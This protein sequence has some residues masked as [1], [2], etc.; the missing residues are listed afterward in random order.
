MRL[1]KHLFLFAFGLFSGIQTT[2]AQ[3]IIFSNAGTTYTNTDVVTSNTY[4]PVDISN[5]T[6]I[7][8]SVNYNFSLGFPGAGNM[9]SSDECP[10]NGG[11]AGD[12]NDPSGAGCDQCWD[13]F[14]AQFQIDGV[15]V[16]TQLV[17]V[18]GNLNQSGTLTFG[19]ICTQNGATA[20]LILQT[21]TWAA[22]ESVT[23]SN[24][25]ITCWDA[26]SANLMANPNPICFGQQFTLSATLTDPASVTS[27]QW[28][29][30]G[31]ITS[32][33]N[34]TTTVTGAPV[35]THTYTLTTTDDNACTET[36]T[37]DMTVNPG[38]TMDDPPNITICANDPVDVAFTGTGSPVYDW[39]NSNIGIGLGAS[40]SGDLSF[41]AANVGSATTGTVTVTPSEGGCIGPSQTFTI[42]VNPLPVVTQPNDVVVC[43]GAPVSVIFA[44]TAGATFNWTNDNTA[45]GLGASGAGNINFNSAS[46]ANQ[47]VGTVTVTP[48]RNGCPGLPITFTITVNPS[49]TVVDPPNQTVCS[50]QQVDINFTG[51]GNPDF[52]WTNSNTAIGLGANG[53]GDLSFTAS[54][55]V[56]NTTGTITVTPNANGCPGPN[57]TFTITV[58][59]LPSVNQPANVTVC[60]G[61][62]VAAIF[63][64]SA[65][66]LFSWSNDNTAIGLG[67][68]GIGNINFS[69]ANVSTQEVATITV[70]PITNNCPGNPVT[71]T[72]TINP[73]PTV[74]DPPNQT[75]CAGATVDLMFSGTVNPDFSWTN[76]NTAIGLGTSGTGDINF[77]AANVAIP[78]TGNL[79]VSPSENGCPG[80]PQNFTITVTPAPVMNQPSNVIACGGTNV[81]VFFIG[82]LG[83]TFNWTNSNPAIGLAAAGNGDLNF[84]ASGVTT[85]QVATITATPTVGSCAGLPV[86]FT[87]TINPAPTVVDP[88]NQ[89]VCSGTAVTVNFTG[90]NTPVFSWTN[91]NTNIGLGVSGTGN[92]SFTATNV[93]IGNVTVTPTAN[94][95]PGPSQTFEINVIGSPVVD[96]IVS[97]NACAGNPVMVAFTGTPG[98]AFS[99]TNSN[100]AIGLGASGTGDISFTAAGVT[101]V[102]TGTISVTPSLG[103]CTGTARNFDI[104]INPL[105]TLSISSVTC[106]ADLLTYSVVVSTNGTTVTAT[107]GTVSGSAGNFTISGIAAGTNVI[108]SSTNTA[109]GCQTTQT[110]NAPNCN[111]TPVAAPTTPNDPV[112]CEGAPIPALTVSVGAGIT[113]DWYS[114]ATGGTLLLMSNTSFTPTGPLAAGTYTFYAEA[115]EISS[116]CVSPVRTLVTLQINA[117]PTLTQP[118]D[119]T[120]CSGATVTADFVGT[121]GASFAWTNSNTNIGLGASG[122]GN[123][124][125]TA[126]NAGNTALT[127]NVVVT[128]SLNGCPGTP[129]NFNLTV[130][131]TP[132]VTAPANQTV[133]AGAMVGISLTGTVGATFDWTNSN[134]AIGLGASG[135]GDINFTASA[136]ASATI[137]NIS[138]TP[139]AGGCPGATQNFSITVNPAPSVTAPGNQS[140]C[141]G[142][143]VAVT[144][145]G[146]SGA[147]FNWTNS[148]T[149]IGLGASG[150]GNISFVGANTGST[151]LVANLV[152]TPNQNGCSG[153]AQNFTITINPLP[154][155]AVGNT[156]CA[157][158][159]LTYSVTVTSNATTLTSTAGTVTGNGSGFNIS[160]IPNGTNVILT[161]TNTSTN[162]STQVSV[163][164]PNCTC[165]TVMVPNGPN[166]PVICEGTAT[167]ALMVNVAPGFTVDWYAALTGGV[168]LLVGSTSFTPPG[169]FTP[170]TYIF[171]AES[172]DVAT[173]C[174]SST[175]TPVFLTVNA[176][177]TMTQPIDQAVC[178]GFVISVGFNGTSGANFNW[179]NSAPGIGL[180]ASGTGNIS[181]TSVNA[182]TTPIVATITVTPTLFG[183]FG[184]PKTFTITV[185]PSPTLTDPTDV[186]ACVGQSVAVNFSA[187]NNAT[188]TW[189]NT[190]T[191]IGLA[192]NGTGNIN[193]NA[194]TA[195]T[196][197][198]TVIPTAN[199]CSG[200]PQTFNIAVLNNPT[201]N[202]PG[203]VTACAGAAVTAG[204]TG[205]PGVNYSWT[206]SNPAIGLPA[207]GTGNISFNAANI[208]TVQSAQINVTPH[209]GACTGQ[210]KIF[211]ITINPLPVASITG[212]TTICNGD[213][214]A[215]TAAGGTSFSWSSGQT[216]ALINV[217]PMSTT[218]Y[219]AT[220]T[221]N[222][223]SATATATVKVNQ[224]T[225]ATVNALTC[226]PTQVGTTTNVITNVAG[227]DSTITTITTLDV[228]GCT[229]TAMLSNG[230]VSCFGNSN[231]VLSLSAA[232]GLGPYQYNWS[233][234]TQTG[235]GQITTAGTSVQLQNLPAGTYTVTVTGAN[236]LT[237]TVTAQVTSPA[238]LTAQATAVL[239]FGQYAISCVGATDATINATTTGG[240]GP[241]QF[242]W[243]EPGQQGAS[244]TGLGV[245]SYGVT[246]TDANLC[247]AT[248]SATVI[249]P[250]PLTF[251]LALAGVECGES[252]AIAS[253]TPSGGVN[254]FDVFV[255]GN[256]ATGGLSPGIPDGI[257]IVEIVDANGCA[258]DTTVEVVLPPVPDI[259]L[260]AELTVTLGETLVLEA[261]TNLTAW[262]SLVWTPQPDTSCIACL[263]QE[264][265]PSTS[266]VYEVDITDT[267]GCSASA[268]VRVIVRKQV[269]IYIPNVFSPNLD[270]INDFWTLDAGLS[271]VSLNSLQI[272]DRWGDMVYFW[273]APIPVDEW[274]GWDG[275]T[276]G[277]KVNPG[278]FVYYLEVTLANG[279]T[280]LKKGDLTVVR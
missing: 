58:V 198:V 38:P 30:P 279:E 49:P 220:V 172:R 244:I 137:A 263:R 227:C 85:Q 190:N 119:Q 2:G 277:E 229:P 265:I 139:T 24:I 221:S 255:D 142:G 230:A 177:P 82:T 146:S 208:L 29:G 102:T 241:F 262:Q 20:G 90:T 228:A 21:Q 107:A 15:N 103:G 224:A 148:N 35:G 204:F 122:N 165:P 161:A 245:G 235:T 72:I 97:V 134:T 187:T 170:G 3:T 57:Q 249:A 239:A 55:V 42:T 152:V 17:G 81:T 260:P 79:T 162:C 191:G 77:I 276:R 254:P 91:D 61:A 116:N 51:T 246:V 236:G 34:L 48:I 280:V 52:N 188:F 215:L 32:P 47:E 69:S 197:V 147:T 278:V 226:D 40:G 68:S 9:E 192:A 46:V 129:L 247:T 264:W 36:N 41:T 234:G 243:T 205:D 163:L 212:V 184:Q 259:V 60:S 211:T 216:T 156:T 96:T 43:A 180:P 213:G 125:F 109:T 203:N 126:T 169:V 44:G 225:T 271:V 217:T 132:S 1:S 22:N 140:A 219:T 112:I 207:S 10:F 18:P 159:L 64:G 266:Q 59:P 74:A 231:G 76:S 261:Q 252:V 71:F 62:P 238:L 105:P 272:F 95:C 181:F 117:V 66:A 5:C 104:T 53:M 167:P 121:I 186:S 182:G 19:P 150:A 33:N 157:P 144:F 253:I 25:T 14:Y 145:S 240:T 135:T 173:G 120:V 118:M 92:I 268:S 83:A 115:R 131:P 6:S 195:G 275:N 114:A 251:D 273:D 175:R 128:P 218:T 45:I 65:G 50:G 201:M 250:P 123:I 171:Y 189:T 214:T 258:A 26:S 8:F 183:C 185:N 101:G 100:T 194:N 158:D 174:V 11:C 7:S 113:V 133:C 78:I 222:G 143:T 110:V 94:G 270:G 84:I 200:T 223:C 63:S 237:Q 232:G 176:T 248:S 179:T 274:P 108:I 178:A 39:T 67:A 89:T 54:T 87:I 70:T 155:I 202:T 12:P 98:A 80:L 75:V 196:A 193:F 13:F 154:T 124:S 149:A 73:T 210:S 31:T 164:A 99:W 56:S 88:P 168:P 257:H 4:G 233:N 269:D 256:L 37:I 206:N 199:G 136:V 23:F 166:F 111:C 141:A 106:A 160:G 153:A 138:V 127:G 27:T 267:L 151:P 86:T 130:N 93:G 16:N 28:S 242:A 209:L